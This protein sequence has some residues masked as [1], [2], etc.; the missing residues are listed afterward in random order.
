MMSRASK[1]NQQGQQ[2]IGEDLA[3]I[4]RIAP[5]SVQ[6]L[7][8]KI[9]N[10][11]V[12]NQLYDVACTSGP[13]KKGN[14]TLLAQYPGA[15]RFDVSC[16]L[17]DEEVGELIKWVE[18]T[19]ASCLNQAY[20]C[21]RKDPAET[22]VPLPH[23][24]LPAHASH[25]CPHADCLAPGAVSAVLHLRK[26]QDT[27][28]GEDLKKEKEELF[29]EGR[30]SKTV[31]NKIKQKLKDAKH[32]YLISETTASKVEPGELVLWEGSRIHCGRRSS[33][34][35]VCPQT[36]LKGRA[37]VF[38]SLVPLDVHKKLG[39]HEQ[40]YAR[41]KTYTTEQPVGFR[42][43][44]S[45]NKASLEVF[46]DTPPPNSPPD[47]TP[48][49]TTPT[50][51]R[52]DGRGKPIQMNT[53]LTKKYPCFSEYRTALRKRDGFEIKKGLAVRLQ[54][55]DLEFTV[56]KV[57]VLKCQDS[58]EYHVALVKETNTPA[59]TF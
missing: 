32:Q 16:V 36:G 21:L 27:W 5:A 51:N 57:G 49:P 22:M 38:F 46:L 45:V 26:Q 53:E 52:H 58:K 13:V 40:D 3:L 18:L 56:L 44:K 4:R 6:T 2:L 42:G 25:Q 43:L 54:N 9:A 37:L 17:S 15:R 39:T 55:V 19:A 59:V 24:I 48:T 34:A 14:I 10:S 20:K 35:G 12:E 8:G 30:A 23:V 11:I 1:I 50:Q 28:I 47:P 29:S 31:I 41:I 7:V 33:G